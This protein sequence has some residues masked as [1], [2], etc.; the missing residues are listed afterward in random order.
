MQKSWVSPVPALVL[1]LFFLLGS[2]AGATAQAP[3]PSAPASPVLELPA[4]AL[5]SEASLADALPGL[6]RQALAVYAEPDRAQFLSTV[7]RLQLVAGRDAEAVETLRALTDLRRASDP[8]SAPRL[9]PFSTWAEARLRHAADGTPLEEAFREEFRA[10]FRQLGDREAIDALF[11]FGGDLEGMR[12]RLAAAVEKQRGKEGIALAEALD[13]ARSYLLLRSFE[14]MMPLVPELSAEDDARR[15][16][17]DREA[18]VP[19]PDGAR[20]AALVVRPKSAKGPLPTLLDFT[21]YAREDWSFDDARKTAAHGYAAVVAYSRGKGRSPGAPVPYERDGDDARAVIDWI[22]GQGWSDGRVGM[23]G[24]SYDGFTQWSAVKRRPKALRALMPS[25]TNVPGVDFPMQG[26]VFLNFTY[27]WGP[28]V[29]KVKGLDEEGYGD[30]ARW[31]RLFKSWYESGRPYRDLEAIDGEPNPVFR[32]WLEHP[33]YDEYWRGLV[34]DGRELA[35][36]DIPILTTTGYY[37]GGQVGALHIFVEHTRHDPKAEHYY[38]IGPYT[39]VGAQRRSEDVVGGYRIDPAARLDV[40]ALRYQWFDY[41]FRGGEK[42]ALLRDRVNYQ[43]MGADEWKHAPSIEAMSRGSR[44][45]YL[46]AASEGGFRRLSEA[47][48]GGGSSLELKVDFADRGAGGDEADY[49]FL[50]RRLET[51]NRIVFATPPFEGPA[52]VSG[53]F[54]GRLDFVVNKKD[55]DLSLDL[56][57]ELPTGEFLQLAVGPA[58]LRRASYARS[59]TERRLLEPGRKQSIEI[60]AERL[61]SRKLQKGS[62][63]LLVLGV[64]KSPEMQIN[65]GTG[66]DVSDESVADAGEP[67]RIRWLGTSHVVIPL[68]R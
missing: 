27:P 46:S 39:H 56:F 14:V 66:K 38:L 40:E 35:A 16:A 41:V 20:I 59:R 61:V 49:E 8:A 51:R 47:K 42:P 15:Y 57:E 13:L 60:R 63:L 43:V 9:Y 53:L 68:S 21:I 50:D 67:L 34:P 23:Y 55:F 17:I 22:A 36:I 45:Y 37:D 1:V 58:Y 18:L 54:T 48:P 44:R 12:S 62:R 29:T 5:Q 32:R 2:V 25:V 31:S 64:P 28:Y 30:A 19:A 7:F 6:A 65:Y 4:A 11:W 52:E 3:P 24:G 33:S 10:L 26:N